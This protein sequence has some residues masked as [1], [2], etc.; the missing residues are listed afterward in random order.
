MLGRTGLALPGGI[1]LDWGMKKP[2]RRPPPGRTEQAP[3]YWTGAH[4]THKLRYHVVLV[5]KYRKRVLNGEV[6][7]RLE[8]LIRQACQVNRWEAEE[9][10]I[11]PDHAHLLI[12]APP[13]FSVS[14]IMR[15]LKG[16][17]SRVLRA[18]FPHLEEHLWGKN[19]W[20]EGFFAATVG[21]V[22]G[23]V[24]TAHIKNQQA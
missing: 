20:A 9:L 15:T 7:A 13:R 24:V 14:R 17:T 10:A 19:F 12:Q 1:V 23:S 21:V 2:S 16:G 11:Q 8:A 22:E 3:R 6:A 5:P 4:T 18:E